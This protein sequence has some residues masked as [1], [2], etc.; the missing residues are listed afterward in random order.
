M[1]G[2]AAI[3]ILGVLAGAVIGHRRGSIVAGILCTAVLGPLFGLAG[4]FAFTSQQPVDGAT[5][6]EERQP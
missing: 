6:H 4:L 1:T 3:W 2:L 5:L